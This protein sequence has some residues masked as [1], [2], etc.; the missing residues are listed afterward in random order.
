[1][2]KATSGPPLAAERSALENEDDG[3]KVTRR[4]MPSIVASTFR[5]PPTA[6]LSGL[7]AATGG[8]AN[9]QWSVIS[10]AS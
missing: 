4:L 5:M 1:M 8:N 7:A 2:A 9:D 10:V 3:Q 6:M